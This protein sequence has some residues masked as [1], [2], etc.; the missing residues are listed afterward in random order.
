[1]PA[2]AFRELPG[3]SLYQ[4]AL[5]RNAIDTVHADAFDGLTNLDLPLSNLQPLED[6]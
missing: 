1:M 2:N 6:P 4:L 5:E 3:S